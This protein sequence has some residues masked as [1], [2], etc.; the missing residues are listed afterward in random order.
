MSV[1]FF[2]ILMAAQSECHMYFY[3]MHLDFFVLDLAIIT[4]LTYG[5][6]SKNI[7]GFFEISKFLHH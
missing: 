1:T 6:L 3:Q 5:S 2:Y 4:L 7:G